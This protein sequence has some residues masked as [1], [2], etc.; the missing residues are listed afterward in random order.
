M[1]ALKQLEHGGCLEKGQKQRPNSQSFCPSN[2]LL[3]KTKLLINHSVYL[4]YGQLLAVSI[5]AV[6]SGT[7]NMSCFKIRHALDPLR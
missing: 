3:F 7:I 5:L 6:M 2:K 1:V 4:H